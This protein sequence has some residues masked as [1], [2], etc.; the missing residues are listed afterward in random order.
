[1]GNPAFCEQ[2]NRKRSIEGCGL[3]A[4]G[5]VRLTAPSPASHRLDESQPAISWQVALQQCL[6]LGVN[7][8]RT[9]MCVL[10]GRR[11]LLVQ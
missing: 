3:F 1:M 2:L 11:S 5:K 4:P 9:G 10:P 8:L 6:L 7:V